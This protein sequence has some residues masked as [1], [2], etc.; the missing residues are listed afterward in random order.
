[1]RELIATV[2]SRGIIVKEDFVA[3]HRWKEAPDE[4]AFLRDFHRHLFKIEVTLNVSHGNRQLEFFDVQK[5]LRSIVRK[6]FEGKRFELSCEQIAEEIGNRLAFNCYPVMLVQVSEDGENAG[7]V[8][9]NT[10]E[11]ASG[12]SAEQPVKLVRTFDGSPN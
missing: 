9:F 1:M 7:V 5:C 8:S 3:F 2:R 4:V 6:E 11:R 12:E 10:H